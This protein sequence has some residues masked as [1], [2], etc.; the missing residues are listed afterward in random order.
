MKQTVLVPK[1]RAGV[2]TADV[3]RTF[4]EKLNV[5]LAIERN[6][7]ELDGEGLELHTAAQIVKAIGRGF[8]PARAFRLLAEDQSLEV[9]E[10]GQLT[11]RRAEAVRARVIGT[12]GRTRNLIESCSGAA[13]SVYGKTIAIIGS[14]EQ[15][16]LAREAIEML[17]AGAMHSSVSRFLLRARRA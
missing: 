2:L 15:I 6:T 9:I 11:E 3:R 14:Y 7:V 8:A 12:G 17:I 16:R 4:E 5:K 10:L 1:E 13:V